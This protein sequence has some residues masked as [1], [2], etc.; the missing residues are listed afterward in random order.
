MQEIGISYVCL[1]SVQYR[2]GNTA[3]LRKFF[4]ELLKST[5]I[6]EPHEHSMKRLEYHI[7]ASFPCN[8]EKLI[9]LSFANS[10]K[11]Q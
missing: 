9:L 11:A 5:G 7:F 10:L 4:L 1:I 6:A 3:C 2:A 8:V